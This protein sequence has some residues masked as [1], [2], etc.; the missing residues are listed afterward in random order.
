M[1]EDFSNFSE[2]T[3]FLNMLY[4]QK[5]RREEVRVDDQKEKKWKQTPL[6]NNK[7]SNCNHNKF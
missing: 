4:N 3:A 7:P 5:Y 6:A 1:D 2:R